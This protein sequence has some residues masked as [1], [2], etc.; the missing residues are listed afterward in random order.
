M[1]VMKRINRPYF[2]FLIWNVFMVLAVHVMTIKHEAGKGISGNGNLGILALFPA[3]ISFI[4]L[5][6]WTVYLCRWW[7][8]DQREY[9]GRKGNNIIVVGA[10]VMSVLSVCWQLH[11][12]EGL[13]LQ[14]NGYT[15]DPGSV[16]Y[17]F[18]W[19]NQYTNTLFY[20]FPIL[21]FGL[22]VSVTVG[23]LLEQFLRPRKLTK[24]S[25]K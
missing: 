24:T 8:C 19:L 7:F 10:L 17:R 11:F 6:L 15:D 18:G 3:L 12:I 14:L 23:W 1:N 20:N 2:V 9:W 4:I 21:L 5:C 16:V 22:S 25:N 13:R